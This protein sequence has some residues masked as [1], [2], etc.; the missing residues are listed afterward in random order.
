MLRR[1]LLSILP[2]LSSKPD[3]L[4]HLIHEVMSFDTSVREEWCYDGGNVVDGWMGLTWDILVKH[5]WFPQWLTIEKNFALSR[6]QEIVEATDSFEIDRDSDNSATSKPTFAAI[7][8]IDLLEAVTEDYRPLMAFHHKLQFLTEIQMGI[9]DMFYNRLD[10][11]LIAFQQQTSA[12]GRIQGASRET[13]ANL[14]GIGGLERLCRIYGSADF[15]EGKMRDWS[16]D[17]FFVELWDELHSRMQGSDAGKHIAGPMTMEQ[18]AERTSNALASDDGSGSLFDETAGAYRRLRVR[19]EDAM[20]DK[21]IYGVREALRPYGRLNAWDVAKHPETGSLTPTAALDSTQTYLAEHLSFLSKVLTSASLRRIG[22]QTILAVQSFLWDKVLARKV[23][24]TAGAAQFRRDIESIISTCNRCLGNGQAERGMG[25][26]KEALVL[27]EL[28]DEHLEEGSEGEDGVEI[29]LWEV[30]RRIF[31]GNESARQ[32][33]EELG[34]VS[35][36]ASDARD[37]LR[38]RVELQD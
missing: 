7:R 21:L 31:E 19:A 36:N 1:K 35:L 27:L 3:L 26:L 11:A 8:I 22:R 17:V 6:Y 5:S 24:S 28:P 25:R 13:Q 12:V 9:F 37:V 34:L 15:L 32:T 18:V 2:Q 10:D 20:Q 38:R 14:F 29:G 16:D 23:F 30:E 33:L 4:S